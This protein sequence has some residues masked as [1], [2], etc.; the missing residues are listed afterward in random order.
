MEM[1]MAD[2]KPGKDSAKRRRKDAERLFGSPDREEV[3]EANEALKEQQTQ[4]RRDG[5]PV[6]DVNV[7]KPI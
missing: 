7:R 3:A 4:Q 1:T 5:D 2:P 6:R